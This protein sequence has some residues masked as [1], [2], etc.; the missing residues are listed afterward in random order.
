MWRHCALVSTGYTL[1]KRWESG[2]TLCRLGSCVAPTL[3][4]TLECHSTCAFEEIG[5]RVHGNKEA[6]E[7]FQRRITS[8][9]RPFNEQIRLSLKKGLVFVCPLNG[10]PTLSFARRGDGVRLERLLSGRRGFAVEPCYVTGLWTAARSALL[11]DR[12]ALTT[13]L[14]NAGWILQD[15]LAHFGSDFGHGGAW[16]NF[17]VVTSD[18]LSK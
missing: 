17:R 1:F 7:Q 12:E 5:E 15:F 9:A 10:R 13:S 11:P 6:K 14:T 4:P 16:V 3:P 8:F 18:Y 2:S